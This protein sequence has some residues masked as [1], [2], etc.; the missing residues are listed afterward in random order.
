M[1]LMGGCCV[2]YL[3][4]KQ[5]VRLSTVVLWYVGLIAI[6]AISLLYTVDMDL[7]ITY[8]MVMSYG[9]LLFITVGEIPDAKTM[10]TKSLAAYAMF[11]VFITIFSVMFPEP[12]ANIMEMLLPTVNTKFAFASGILGQTGTNS[13]VITYSVLFWLVRMNTKEKI[14]I[15]SLIMLSISL[16]A[17]LLTGKRGPLVWV[18]VT[19]V[20]VNFIKGYVTGKTEILK[21]LMRYALGAGI[22]LLVVTLLDQT[23]MVEKFFAR[24]SSVDEEDISS[25]RFDL[26]RLA[27]QRIKDNFI[28][29]IGAGAYNHY[30]LGAHNDYLQIFAENGLVG[31]IWFVLF[32]LWNLRNTYRWYRNKRSEIDLYALSLLI[33]IFLN[34][35]TA[36]AFLHYGFYFVFILISGASYHESLHGSPKSLQAPSQNY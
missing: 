18:M 16:F 25:G 4:S 3:F 22:L 12:F 24:F 10:V 11:N 6:M 21:D 32:L 9:L 33:F 20:F 19:F 5:S 34:G 13:Y 23:E 1:I 28:L 15:K 36:T 30:G 27:I 17:L 7:T 26:Y 31:G 29:G 35:L 2:L 8:L 14:D